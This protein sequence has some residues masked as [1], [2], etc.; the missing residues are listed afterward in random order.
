MARKKTATV[1]GI[2]YNLPEGVGENFSLGVAFKSLLKA[3]EV[4]GDTSVLEAL[5]PWLPETPEGKK[6]LDKKKEAKCKKPAPKPKKKAEG[7]VILTMTMVE[8]EVLRCALGSLAGVGES[9]KGKNPK[10]IAENI[11]FNLVN[12]KVGHVYKCRSG[13]S[14]PRNWKDFYKGGKR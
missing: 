2:E 7:E 10:R 9:E 13:G 11:H 12:Q 8:A 4:C 3:L 5:Y 6:I 1:D 14:I